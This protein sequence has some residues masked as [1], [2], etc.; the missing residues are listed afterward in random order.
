MAGWLEVDG[1]S[2]RKSKK[3]LTEEVDTKRVDMISPMPEQHTTGAQTH[4]YTYAAIYSQLVE[5]AAFIHIHQGTQFNRQQGILKRSLSHHQHTRRRVPVSPSLSRLENSS[6][7]QR[8]NSRK[9]PLPTISDDDVS[10]MSCHATLL[11]AIL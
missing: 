4:K 7:D 1:K 8:P 10:A 5:A 3:T 2:E 9:V 6:S 11:Y